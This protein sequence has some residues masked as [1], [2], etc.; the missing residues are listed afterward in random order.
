MAEDGTLL[1]VE[2]ALD[3]TPIPV[4]R[5]IKAQVGEGTIENV[6][7][8]F[9]EDEISYDVDI[10]RKDGA[11]RSFSVTLAG[12]LQALQVALEE[13][14]AAVR[15]IIETSLGSA[16]LED[17]HH[18][19]EEGETSYYV[20]VRRDGKLRDFSVA[21]NGKLESVMVFLSET[22]AEVRSTINEKI[23]TGKL[24]RVDKSFE[25]RRGVL[26]Y[27]IEARKDGKP[28]NFSVGPKGRF[29]GMDN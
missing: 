25:A 11:E 3:E 24:L 16:K 12:R 26:P 23:G 9:D 4:Q 1:S 10:K 6:E 15:K 5:T 19:F 8:S 29:L 7:Q 13:T 28:F 2:V 22:P 20:E 27:E 21:E 14:P 17:I 18:I